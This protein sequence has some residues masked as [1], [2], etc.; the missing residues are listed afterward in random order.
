MKELFIVNDCLIGGHFVGK[1]DSIRIGL[2]TTI[3]G[4]G[5]G[6]EI[7]VVLGKNSS[8]T[9]TQIQL[10]E[11]GSHIR[12]KT[13]TDFKVWASLG[14]GWVSRANAG[15]RDIEIDFA[16][17]EGSAFILSPSADSARGTFP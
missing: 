15:V 6:V 13:R 14:Q 11:K 10:S 16:A 1:S 9:S 2:E 3:W 5:P 7:W 4:L 17:K 12:A 8:W